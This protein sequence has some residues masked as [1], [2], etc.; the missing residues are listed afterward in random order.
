VNLQ[1]SANNLQDCTFGR[2]A[3]ATKDTG[4]KAS[5]ME[6]GSRHCRM[7]PS[8]TAIGRKGDQLDRACANTL[9]EPSTQVVGSMDNL[10][11]LESKYS[12]TERSTQAIGL[13]A[14]QTVE[15]SR[16]CLMGQYMMETG[17]MENS[18]KAN[19]H[20]L[21][22]NYMKENGWTANHMVLV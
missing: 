17:M 14:R 15:V 12:Q 3:N 16:H 20:T 11:E 8:L 2:T 9:M 19:V 5:F 1:F 7:G 13:T 4:V 6:K 18:K 10:M 22:A 21:M